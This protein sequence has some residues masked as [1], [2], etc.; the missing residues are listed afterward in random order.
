[1]N[2]GLMV[3]TDNLNAAWYAVPVFP[4]TMIICT[5]HYNETTC[6]F[7]YSVVVPISN[8][9]AFVY[10]CI[11]LQGRNIIG[12]FESNATCSFYLS[13]EQIVFN[14][15][16]QDN[17]IISINGDNTGIYG[18]ADDF[19]F[20]YELNSTFQLIVWPNSL[21]ISPRAVDI[22]ANIDYAVVVGYCQLAPAYAVDCGFIVSLNRS[23][24]CPNSTN[25]FSMINSNQ[26]AYSDPR[27]NQYLTNSRDYSAQTVMS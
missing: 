27:I 18:F 17:F 5:I 12:L 25:A 24:S 13:N 11:D 8:I 7:V 16:T 23:L 10:N 26:F 22:G 15:S 4:N 9:S 6:D 3:F 20:Y 14:Y 19:L 21:N 2:D 1:M